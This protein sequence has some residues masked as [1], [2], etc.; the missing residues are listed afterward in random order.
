M[1]NKSNFTRRNFLA[2]AATAAAG[3]LSFLRIQLPDLGT[4]FLATN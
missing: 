3:L 2:T 1:E 4:K